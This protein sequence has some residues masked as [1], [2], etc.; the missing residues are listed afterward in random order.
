MLEK[1]PRG[2]GHALRG[3]RAGYEKIIA[4]DNAFARIPD[5]IIL[6]SPAFAD[7]A[8]I[9]FALGINPSRTIA[10]LAERN[11]AIMLKEAAAKPA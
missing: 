5:S 9:P 8:I 1:M 10:A 3:V 11:A 2:L 7:G 6:E 4:E